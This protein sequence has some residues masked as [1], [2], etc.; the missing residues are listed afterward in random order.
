MLAA[1]MLGATAGL[2]SMVTKGWQGGDLSLVLVAVISI[3]IIGYLLSTVLSKLEKVICP[4]NNG[5]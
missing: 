3:A 5:K 1:E 2:G 4:W